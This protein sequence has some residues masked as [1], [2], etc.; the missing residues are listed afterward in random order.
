MRTASTLLQTIALGA[1]LAAQVHGAVTMPGIRQAL[2]II[3][4]QPAPVFCSSAVQIASAS[5]SD[6]DAAA[7]QPCP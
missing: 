5:P 2:R 7:I 4:G 6:T 3:G 1:L